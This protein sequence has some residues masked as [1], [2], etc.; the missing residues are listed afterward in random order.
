MAIE[1]ITKAYGLVPTTPSTGTLGLE[2]PSPAA[3]FGS[4]ISSNL[5]KMGGY[6]PMALPYSQREDAKIAGLKQLAE[7]LYGISAKLSGDPAKMAL[8]QEMQKAKQPKA[9]QAYKP[10][11][12]NYKNVTDQN[13]SV[14]SYIIKPG[15]S[16]PF[17]VAIPE[18][19]NAISGTKG[20][21]EVKDRTVYTRQGSL[22]MTKDGDYREI[23]RGDKRIFSGPM[24]E[25]DPGA[26]FARYPESRSKTSGEEQ[27][28][29]PDFKTFVGL[30]KDLATEERS[31]NKIVSYWE[32]IKDTNVGVE[33]LGDQ[34]STWFKTLAGRYD[35]TPQELARGIAEG[36]LQGLIG[37]NRIDTVGGGV[38]TE[39]DAWRIIARLGGDVDS[40]QNPAIVG[41]LL[42]EMYRDKVT[43]YNQDI[44]GYNIGVDSQKYSGYEKRT[45]ITTDEVIE[46]FTILPPGVPAGSK[47]VNVGGIILYQKDDTYYGIDPVSGLVDEVEIDL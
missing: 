10:E 8:Y 2:A 17:N 5:I 33:R 3:R 36:K 22:Y 40:L 24:G 44:K 34:I 4:R 43:Q 29:I 11:L 15:E 35:L 12:V 26:F 32:N 45:P 14:G 13:I 21:E 37:A 25:F 7:R 47:K 27:R 20:L 42:E 39:K 31:L 1:D 46:L 28:Y 30:N 6:D 9:G 19:A 16:V 23:I 38:M 18:I 41:P